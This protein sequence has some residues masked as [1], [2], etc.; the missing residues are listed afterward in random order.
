VFQ[1]SKA[2]YMAKRDVFVFTGTLV[3]GDAVPGMFVDLPRSMGGPGPVRIE[4]VDVVAFAGGRHELA[5]TV[6]YEALE[7]VPL[8]EPSTVEGRALSLTR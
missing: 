7:S 2:F 3:Y 5:L 4:S 8:W 1:V 6:P